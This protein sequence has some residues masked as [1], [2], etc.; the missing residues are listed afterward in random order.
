MTQFLAH[1]NSSIGKALETNFS[2]SALWKY[3]YDVK[4][5]AYT[6][7]KFKERWDK[8]G[9]TV[10]ESSN[11]ELAVGF[12]ETLSA[13][14]GHPQVVGFNCAA[15]HTAKYTF[16]QNG[17]TKTFFINGAPAKRSRTLCR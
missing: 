11:K 3:L 17:N 16:T 9:Y 4:T 10:D 5:A 8:W 6:S 1:K 7:V 2:L 15:C 12:A 14:E 13:K